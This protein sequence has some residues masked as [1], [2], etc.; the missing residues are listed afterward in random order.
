M[1]DLKKVRKI[2]LIGIGGIGMSAL[3]VILQKRG[4]EVL[5]SDKLNSKTV[6]I[7][8]ESGIS[9]FIGHSKDNISQDIDLVVY[10][11]AIKD[12]NPE[13]LKAKELDIPVIERAKML[14]ILSSSKR[15]I[16][17]SGTHGKTTTTSMIA[18]IFLNASKDPTIAVG[19]H[20]DEINGSGYEGTGKYF[21]YE[22]CEAF[23][24]FHKLFPDIAVVTN[25]D[26]DHLDYYENF[27]NLKNAFYQYLNNNV[28]SSG[29]IIYNSDDEPLNSVVKKIKNKRK[30]SVG[31][32]NQ[33]AEFVAMDIVLDEFSSN[34][35]VF[36]QGKILGEF[37]INIPGVH[38]VYNALLAIATAYENNIANEHINKTFANFQNAERRFQ[39]KLRSQ[40]LTVI[41]DYAHHPSEI[42]ATLA[43]ATNLS[44]RHNAALIA[45]FQPHLYSRTQ[46]LYKEFAKSLSV[47]D[48]VVLTDIYASREQNENN[49]STKLIYDEIVKIKPK[50][51]V[52][53]VE[54]LE[55]IIDGAIKPLL[56]QGKSIVI[57]LG[58][59]DIWKIAE[60]LSSK[61]PNLLFS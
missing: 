9:V 58:A 29:A 22:A 57:T 28:S 33:Q 15:S 40:N 60:E 36:R 44:A 59:G 34:F 52:F 8:K 3:A 49:V 53:Y 56:S 38:N 25:I 42:A 50:E 47:A 35:A 16:A 26:D 43:A 37:F 14:N 51:D 5:G 24:S 20:L 23:G 21:I 4:F 11:N 17:I 1:D 18:K 54:K 6:E 32:K 10:T 30:I 12:D 13:Y 39:V 46:Q 27:E 7:L 31:I 55:N 2:F 45:V 19:G 61:F 48:K 41:D